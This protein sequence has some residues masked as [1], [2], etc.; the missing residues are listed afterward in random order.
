LRRDLKPKKPAGIRRKSDCKP[1]CG[2]RGVSFCGGTH[3]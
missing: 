3:A 2:A 1:P